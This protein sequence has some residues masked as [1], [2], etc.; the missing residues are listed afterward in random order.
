M[1]LDYE[2]VDWNELNELVISKRLDRRQETEDFARGIRKRQLER[3]NFEGQS[4]KKKIALE[5]ISTLEEESNEDNKEPHSSSSDNCI[6]SNTHNSS[7]DKNESE[8]NNAADII[9][10]DPSLWRSD[11]PSFVDETYAELSMLSSKLTKKYIWCLSLSEL[12]TIAT[13][14]VEMSTANVAVKE[15]YDNT[16]NTA[17]TGVIK[18]TDLNA[19]LC[20]SGLFKGEDHLLQPISV[21][22][23]VQRTLSPFMVQNIEI[24]VST[25]NN[26]DLL[27]LD[28]SV[29]NKEELQINH[30]LQD[31]Y[32]KHS[33]AKL[34]DCSE[35][36]SIADCISCLF[37]TLWSSKE[38]VHLVWDNT[39]VE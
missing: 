1:D 10:D 14:K 27:L 11:G 34:R 5:Q 4:S 13:E 30:I 33:A 32:F 17:A 16:H 18:N 38:N 15:L 12:C 25:M 9:Y 37:G 22:F 3:N 20:L 21:G 8:S 28:Y 36:S 39:V 19:R 31:I 29:S 26:D 35:L 2:N 23:I 6:S 24:L 7:S